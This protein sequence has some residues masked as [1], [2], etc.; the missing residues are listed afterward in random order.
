MKM[1]KILKLTVV[2]LILGSL[3]TGAYALTDQEKLDM[4]QEKFLKGEISEATYLRLE[5]QFKSKL[6]GGPEAKTSAQAAASG[7]LVIN[8]DFEGGADSQGIPKGWNTRWWGIQCQL[9]KEVF[10][11]GKQSAK[12]FHKGPKKVC[13]YLFQNVPVAA[14]TQYRFSAYWK[15]EGVKT[16]GGD[17]ETIILSVK[18]GK[19][20][21]FRSVVRSGQKIDKFTPLTGK[22]TTPPGT[23]QVR[24][25]LMYFECEGTVWLDDVTLTKFAE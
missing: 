6:A 12:L 8:G 9:D 23:N 1:K 3:Y 4:L 16:I 21:L 14:N 5:K 17:S 22:L 10:H 25:T 2:I 18:A 11:G 13:S 19:K 20:G 7:N 24:I 15:T